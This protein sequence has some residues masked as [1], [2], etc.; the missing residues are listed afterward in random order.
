MKKILSRSGI[1][2]IAVAML[3]TS[4]V[5]KKKYVEAQNTIEKYRNDSTQL[6]QQAASLQQNISSLEEK[7]KTMQAQ[8]DSSK[9]V[10][11]AEM[12]RWSGLQTYY[13]QQKTSITGLHQQ[14]HDALSS[15]EVVS[16]DEITAS[17][18]RV[19]VT[20]DD[21]V[22][23]GG[24]LSTKGKKAIADFAN[25]IKDKEDM[26]VDVA[27]GDSYA[28]YWNKGTGA[29]GMAGNE[30]S[31]AGNDTKADA[32]NDNAAVSADKDV[33]ATARTKSTY[34]RPSSATARKSSTATRSTRATAARRSTAKKTYR[35]ESGRSMSFKSKSKSSKSNS[36]NSNIA[37][38]TAIA[39]ELH[40]NGVYNV[41]MLVPGSANAAA[42]STGKSNFQLIVSPKGDRYYQMIESASPA[43]DANGTGNQPAS[44]AQ[45]GTGT[46]GNQ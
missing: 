33:T 43:K 28:A 39:K 8:W 34:R 4:C 25:V 37:K 12:Q 10:A 31:A 14:L 9:A 45:P 35:S 22:F 46:G 20:L 41:G 1:G 32:A 23:S 15:S 27:S 18:G 36:W 6:A 26:V 38:A 5:S 17:N 19:Y 42:T 7:N 24:Q 44:G 29:D 11:Q 3:L 13:D 21:Q 2:A 40:K 30:T 16:A